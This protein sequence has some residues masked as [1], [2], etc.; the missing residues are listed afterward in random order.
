MVLST[1]TLFERES[2]GDDRKFLYKHPFSYL[3]LDEAHALN[4]NSQRF[5]NLN[6]IDLSADCCCPVRLCRTSVG[7]SSIPTFLMPRLFT[8]HSCEVLVIYGWEKSGKSSGSAKGLDSL[9]KML[10]PFVLRRM[11]VHVLDQLVCK[12]TRR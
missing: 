8:P 3:V 12:L 1:Y 10:V 4:S 6:G 2:N 11:K 5:A 7:V 9:R